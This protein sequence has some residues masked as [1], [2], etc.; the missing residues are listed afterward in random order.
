LWKIIFI[1]CLLIASGIVLGVF[2]G[3]NIL[4]LIA[5]EDIDELKAKGPYFSIFIFFA[6][7]II[8]GWGTIIM[9]R[10][11]CSLQIKESTIGTILS[12]ELES[13]YE[14]GAD[15]YRIYSTVRYFVNGHQYERQGRIDF[16]SR[17]KE[18]A[19]ERLESLKYEDSITIKYDPKNPNLMSIDSS[20]KAAHGEILSGIGFM[21]G[22]TLLS[23]LLGTVLG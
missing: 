6:L 21:I 14:D 19:K 9:F 12:S 3:Q 20:S 4:F 11:I 23:I 13:T 8:Y 1:C 10:G 7:L 18:E 5:V 15:E 17:N 2:W 16:F 22:G